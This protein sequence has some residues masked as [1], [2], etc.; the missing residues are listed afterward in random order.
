MSSLKRRHAAVLAAAMLSLSLVP[1]AQAHQADAR[2]KQT[3][4]QPA[5]S[6]A[7]ATRNNP[8]WPEGSPDYHGS[9]GG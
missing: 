5:T 8:S 6:D 2:H 7:S 3:Y 1:A 9:N 4:S